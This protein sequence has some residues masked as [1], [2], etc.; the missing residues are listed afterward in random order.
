M[1]HRRV[2]ENYYNDINNL[3]DLL[4]KLVSSY[5][6]LIGGADELNKIALSKKS[7]VK[8]ALKRAEEVGDIID[9]TIKVLDDASY[10]YRSYCKMKTEIMK[11]KFQIEY[12]ETEIN[13]D[14]RLKD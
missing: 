3:A 6:L 12:I 5:R 8:D 10:G 4:T 14:L 9:E 1:A 2:V 13:E 11:S 7:D